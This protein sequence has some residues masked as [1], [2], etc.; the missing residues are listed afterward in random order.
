M[1]SWV[2]AWGKDR[3]GVQLE[4][5]CR[6]LAISLA[7]THRFQVLKG[8][9][10][11]VTKT[12]E[13]LWPFCIWKWHM[14]NQVYTCTLSFLTK[15][16]TAYGVWLERFSLPRSSGRYVQGWCFCLLC[17]AWIRHNIARD[18]KSMISAYLVC[19]HT[20]PLRKPPGFSRSF[21]LMT[22]F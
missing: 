13:D 1:A 5:H 21:I 12:D 2:K 4:D 19:V 17:L 7:Q 20:W 11:A 14:H 16:K 8:I 6:L 3:G 10:Q 15:W 9:M 18:N 22:L